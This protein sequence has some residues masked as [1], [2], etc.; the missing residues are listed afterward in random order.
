MI[1]ST[2][3]FI[4]KEQFG[5]KKGD[6]IFQNKHMMKA[7]VENADYMDISEDEAK[8]IKRIYKQVK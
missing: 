5:D 7:I 1:R 2:L 4:F 8:L 3:K 6:E